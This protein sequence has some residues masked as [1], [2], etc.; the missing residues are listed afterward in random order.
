MIEIIEPGNSVFLQRLL[1]RYRQALMKVD[2]YIV[3]P[4][5]VTL[6]LDRFARRQ[7]NGLFYKDGSTAKGFVVFKLGQSMVYVSMFFALRGE[8]KSHVLDSLFRHLKEIFP[9]MKILVAESAPDTSLKT[10]SSILK[11][12]GFVRMDRFKM[13]LWAKEASID[14]KRPSGFVFRKY[15][16]EF[17]HLLGD[18]D[19]RAYKGQPDEILLKA[20]A[21]IGETGPS[22]RLVE[23][24]GLFESGLSAFAFHGNDLAGAVYCTKS[25]RKLGIANIAIDPEYQSRGLG[26]ALLGRVVGKMEGKGFRR[27]ELLVSKENKKAI[28]LYKKIGFKLKRICPIFVYHTGQGV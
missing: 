18:L 28:V 7:E 12:L 16:P 21:D 20:F 14:H 19:K 22:L 17:R 4:E 3:G 11:R 26:K 27:C 6:M 24:K 23:E 9:G 2:D 5:W 10:Q 1:E 13:R 8:N 25:G 15:N